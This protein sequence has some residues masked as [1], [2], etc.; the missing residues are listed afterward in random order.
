MILAI[1]GRRDS[2]TDAIEDYCRLLGGAF[3][4]SGSD[5]KLTRVPW[6]KK[7]WLR[8][9]INLWRESADWRQDWALVQYTALTWS[10]RG[11]PTRFLLVL[12]VLRM[13][14]VRTAVVFHDPQGF[15]GSRFVDRVRR[16]C[17]RAVM[18]WTCRFSDASIITI[19]LEQITWLPY[20]H[21]K[22]TFIQTCATLP[23]VGAEGRFLRTRNEVKT[24]TVFAVTDGGDNSREV[25]DIS[26]AARRAAE[27]LPHVR[28]VTIGRGSARSEFMFREALKGSSVEF[29]ALGILPAEEISRVIADSDV[30]LFVRGPITTQR[31]SAIASIANAVPLVAYSDPSPPASIAEAGV[32]CVPYLDGEKLAEATVRVLTDPQLWRDLHERSVRAQKN[33]FSSEAVANRFLDI[34]H[35]A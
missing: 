29:S 12:G 5:F 1:L 2:P 8:A 15:G 21:R 7:G 14:G 3:K 6:D 20:P 33:Y 13:H 16:T 22:A 23:A 4:E 26:L 28:L 30:S 10:R 32:V 35:N 27:H 34:L 11:F 17:Q 9:L 25:A 31:S 19:P 18:N 24:I